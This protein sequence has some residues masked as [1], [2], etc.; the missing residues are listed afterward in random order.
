MIEGASGKMLKV[1][2]SDFE[3]GALVKALNVCDKDCKC[4]LSKKLDT[5]DYYALLKAVTKLDG[6]I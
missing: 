1:E 6:L 3:I 4:N 2:L 5:D